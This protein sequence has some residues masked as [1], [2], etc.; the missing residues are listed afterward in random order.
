MSYFQ[1]PRKQWTESCGRE[2]FPGTTSWLQPPSR[3]RQRPRRRRQRTR[4]WR[5]ERRPLAPPRK[6]NEASQNPG[7]NRS[8]PQS[9]GNSPPLASRLGRETEGV[10][11]TPRLPAVGAIGML[12][13]R[14]PSF[15]RL[16]K[17]LYDCKQK[18]SAIAEFQSQWIPPG[19]F[20]S[21]PWTL[22]I[23]FSG[24]DRDERGVLPDFGV[25][26]LAKKKIFYVNV[27]IP[28]VDNSTKSSKEKEKADKI[29][30][31]L[32]LTRDLPWCGCWGNGCL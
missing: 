17:E 23:P 7:R 5:R 11:V 6:R 10:E 14:K 30:K 9:R 24:W 3:W 26:G 13:G 12:D 20:L 21:I 2:V 25:V 27:S 29:Q 31:D 19:P 15:F 16:E 22:W 28:L 18:P 8:L 32:A 4:R 1:L